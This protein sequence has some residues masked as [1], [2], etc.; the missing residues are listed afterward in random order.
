MKFGEVLLRLVS[1]YANYQGPFDSPKAHLKLLQAFRAFKHQII[2][3][4]RTW[5]WFQYSH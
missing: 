1:I 2:Y 3:F 5:L 4:F